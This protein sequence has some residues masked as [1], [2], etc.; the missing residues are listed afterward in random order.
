MDINKVWLTGQATS[1]PVLSKISSQTDKAVFTLSSRETF[2]NKSGDLN[3]HKNEIE[4]ECLGKAASRIASLV[5]RG[6]RYTVEGYLRIDKVGNRSRVVV[7]VFAVYK[8]ETHQGEVYKQAI[9]TA[10]DI[11]KTSVDKESAID[12]LQEILK[13]E[14]G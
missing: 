6:G 13:P 5:K 11:V 7:R 3:F 9:A 10:R 14:D 2:H 12:K 4:I 1:A 8:D